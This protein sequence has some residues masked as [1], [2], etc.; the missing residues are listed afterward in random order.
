MT[1]VCFWRRISLQSNYIFVVQ[2]WRY[3]GL[4]FIF[5]LFNNRWGAH[6]RVIVLGSIEIVVGV[7]H[8]IR[9]G[10]FVR[11][12]EFCSDWLENTITSS[13]SRVDPHI[14]IDQG[15]RQN[16]LHD[17]SINCIFTKVHA[18][19]HFLNLAEFIVSRRVPNTERLLWDLLRSLL[20]H[21]FNE[22]IFTVFRL[23]DTILTELVH[24]ISLMHW[25][26]NRCGKLSQSFQPHILHKVNLLV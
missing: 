15:G 10:V 13:N 6:I 25:H 16:L 11:S 12:C 1:Y 4:R 20:L 14:V 19:R 17:A 7:W 8:R 24:K 21:H 3:I 26:V 22:S 9:V 23:C 2:Q 18:L 5:H